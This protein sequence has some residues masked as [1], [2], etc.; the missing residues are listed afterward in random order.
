MTKPTDAEGLVAL[1][2][3]HSDAGRIVEAEAAY[4]A[5]ITASPAWSVPWY[6]LGLLYKYQGRWQESY[7]FNQ[8]A[9]ELAP[10]E[11]AAW[12]NLGIAATALGQWADARRAWQACGFEMP[13]GDG[14]L[15]LNYGSVPVRLDPDGVA[16]VVW[17][18]RLDPA[19]AEILSVPLPTSLFR[20][21]DIVLHDGAAQGYRARHGEQIPV[22]NVLTRLEPSPYQTFIL[23]L[24][25]SDRAA[26]E[27]L[28][29]VA[30]E[31]GGAAEDWGSTTNILCRKCSLGLPHYHRDGSRNPAHPHCGVAARDA[32][33]LELILSK[34]LAASPAADL[35]RWQPASGVP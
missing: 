25:T 2:N 32:A 16:E 24:A 1:G 22:F 23:E 28:E 7:E 20:W 5:A 19:R 6:D 4:R 29:Q 14:P 18:H 11:E 21:H 13:P 26:I 34:W 12:W 31:A 3:E 33:H 9:A 30:E 17:A 10:D 35:V 15:D 8:K 27:T